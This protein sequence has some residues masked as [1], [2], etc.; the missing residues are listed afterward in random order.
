MP[1]PNPRLLMCRPDHFGIEYE[2]NPWMDTARGAD[3]PLALTQW[4]ALV[5]LLRSFGATVEL[6][7]PVPGLPDLVFTANAGLV[8]REL[9]FPSVFRHAQRQGEEP[10]FARWMAGRGRQIR[11]L[12]SGANFEGAGDALFCGRTLFAGYLKRSDIASHADLAALL[13]CEVISLELV[14]PRFYHLDTCFCPLAP[15]VAMAYLP[16]F[17][18][19]AQ[20]A[21][22]AAVPELIEVPAAA[23]QDF[24][25][26]AAVVNG[27]VAFNA[28]RDGGAALSALL[29]PRGFRCS[30]TPLGEF[31]KAGGG[32][33][34]LTFRLDG[35]DAADWP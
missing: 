1:K 10:H 11:P 19:Y 33:K 14:D 5:A 27:N 17:D 13:G 3:R 29:E 26:N 23:A 12:P 32:A 9:F 24:A 4:E 15:G 22:R 35:E 25:C 16:A 28:G 34:C 6:L 21:L 2:I 18:E 8:W 7:D 20:T 30:P 31:L